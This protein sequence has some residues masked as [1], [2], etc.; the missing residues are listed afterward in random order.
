M[1]WRKVW[2]DNGNLGISSLGKSWIFLAENVEGEKKI[3]GRAP[4]ITVKLKVEKESILRQ[5]FQRQGEN[6]RTAELS[7]GS[8]FSRQRIR[9]SVTGERSF[10]GGWTR[11]GRA[12]VRL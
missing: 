6:L 11:G 10:C 9:T 4:A 8:E 5:N 1:L 7:K 12:R 2:G 3:Y